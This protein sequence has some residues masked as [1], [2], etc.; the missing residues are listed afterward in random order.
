MEEKHTVQ[1]SGHRDRP[2]PFPEEV[3]LAGIAFAVIVI[4]WTGRDKER[5]ENDRGEGIPEVGIHLAEEDIR[6]AE[7]DIRPAE[8]DIQV[9]QR[10]AGGIEGR[11][12]RSIPDQTW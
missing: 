4:S 5:K 3:V 8:E 11:E 2:S 7:G 6:P 9:R 12:L 10:S 1:L